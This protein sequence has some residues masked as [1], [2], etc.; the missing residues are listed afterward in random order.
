MAEHDGV[1]WLVDPDG[2]RFVSKGV[3]TVRLDQ[4]R[5]RNSDRIPYAEACHRKYGNQDAWR[6]SVAR[7]LARWGFNT[8]GA[9][10]DEA[11]ASA[12]AVPLATAPLLDLGMSYTWRNGGQMPEPTQ[13]F[14][15]VFD[16]AFERHVRA[17]SR[18]L[19]GGRQQ[20]QNILGWF[21]DNEL[22]W[23]PDWRGGDELL[24][25]FLNLGA[26]APGRRAAL[27]WLQVRHRDFNSSNSIWRSSAR[28]WDEFENLPRL[29]QPYRRKPIYQRTAADED[30]ANSA[31]PNRA[32]FA[33]GCEAFSALVAERYFALT[34]MAIRAADPNH[35]LLGCRFAYVPSQEVVDP[36]GRY[37]DVISFN[38]YDRDATAAIEAYAAAGKPCLIG[39]FSFR[40]VDSGLPNSNGAGPLVATQTERAAGFQ[41]YVTA[42]LQAR[43]LVGYHW[44]ENADQPDAGR[45]DGEDSNFGTVTIDDHV[46]E[47]LTQTMTSLNGVAEDVH[48]TAHCAAK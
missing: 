14:P 38:C 12:G 11:V 34:T 21:V 4:D 13:E 5:V 16:P 26:H 23:G 35:L 28:S 8:L 29:A 25:L 31:D 22:C 15:D 3:N 48:A 1:F 45:F 46:Y 47:Q 37:N 2:G 18:N 43:N 9:W 41:H 44:F 42:A 6:A 17:R 10:S 7:R 19:C 30:A 32:V 24:T 36:A 27:N 39:E 20:D 33:A 40:G